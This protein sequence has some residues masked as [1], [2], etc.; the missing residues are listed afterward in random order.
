M[1]EQITFLP[2]LRR[3]LAQALTTIDPLKGALARGPEITASID[4]VDGAHAQRTVRLY[5]PDHVTGLAPGQAL[6]SEPRPDSVEVEPTLFPYVELAAP[7]L[8]WL[9]TP[10]KPTN[11]G[12]LRPWLVLVVVREQEGVELALRESDLPL[13]TIDGALGTGE[14]QDLEDSWAWVHVQSLVGLEGTADAVSAGSGEVVARLV[15]PRRL[16]PN[17]SW[18][19]CVVPAFVDD[20]AAW[21]PAWERDGTA[22]P[23][24]VYHHWRF[25]TGPAGDFEALCRR[26]KPDDSGV[27]FGLHPM[28]V[29]DP[30]L[31]APASRRVV[32][33][34]Q[35]AL[36][37]DGARPRPWKDPEPFQR[38]LEP[39]LNAAAVRAQYDSR[40]REPIVGPPLYGMWPAGVRRVRDG[41]VSDVNLDP[42]KRAAAGLG[43]RVV[44]ATQETLVADAW[45]QAESLRATTVAVNQ[46]RLAVEIGRVLTARTAALDDGDALHL[47]APL[48][49]LLGKGVQSIEAR[50]RA[51]AV[52]AGLVTST[53]LRLTR[54]DTPLARDYTTLENAPGARLGAEHIQTTLS[55]TA[56]DSDGVALE[57]A[58][59]G[60]LAGAQVSDLTLERPAPLPPAAANR[61]PR[62]VDPHPLP[63]P[64][65]VPV[66][67]P[68]GG[69][70]VSDIAADVIAALDPLD[71]VRA[72]LLA[73]VPALAEALPAGELPTRL[74]LAPRFDDALYDDLV[75]LSPAFLMPG[76][77]ALGRNRVR[78]VET[79]SEFV[80][81]LLVGA[82]DQLARELLWR[83]YPVDLRA[84]FLHR[85]WSYVDGETDDIGELRDWTVGDSLTK[86]LRATAKEMTVFV[87]RGDIVRR[88]PTAHY[89]LQ[90]AQ[91]DAGT[92]D[93]GPVPHDVEEACFRGALDPDTLFVGFEKTSSEV[94]GDR[95]G[96]GDP[97]WLFA[98][99]EQPAAPRFGLDDPARGAAY[100]QAPKSWDDLSWANVARDKAALD[101][102]THA[103]I[104]VD[105]LTT[106]TVPGATWGRNAAHMARA[107][108][109][110][111]FRMFIPADQLV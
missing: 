78:L 7:D 49:A 69:D 59:Y 75:A 45:R 60:R 4:L 31:I 35:G 18:L 89:F 52:P 77:G 20:G 62:A 90:R 106:A 73:R 96:G 85:F 68:A 14:L 39:L 86:N 33:D 22:P 71:A 76:A 15:C 79:N 19:A 53:H 12:Q 11:D 27:E 30:G 25:S 72:S 43:A 100:H 21:Q 17:S 58:R 88:Y 23:L 105:W 97:G 83:D 26:L 98:I 50:L 51:S 29:T 81:A 6:R 9:Y 32:L 16:L 107:C 61:L 80:A 92:G 38:P 8:P 70:D 54:P 94:I 111:P 63:D 40:V 95:A 37:T 110:R 67:I 36:H 99:E 87:V 104:D 10:A 108:W 82:N 3:G 28:D 102:L 24:P 5:G 13:L 93:I 2:W 84:T 64:E 48:H 47:T 66:P 42:V 65:P 103:P 101:A 46:G 56:E 91:I 55:A 44:Q 41:W 109:Q 1:K 34:Y 57:F 74:A